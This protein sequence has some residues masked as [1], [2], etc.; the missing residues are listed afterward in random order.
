LVLFWIAI[1]KSRREEGRSGEEGITYRF[2]TPVEEEEKG[3]FGVVLRV[4]WVGFYGR[5]FL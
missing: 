5:D 2:A 1:Y 3:G 4:G